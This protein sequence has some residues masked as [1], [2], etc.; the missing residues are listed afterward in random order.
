MSMRQCAPR[1]P[2]SRRAPAPRNIPRLRV[3]TTMLAMP[4]SAAA[5]TASALPGS[6]P[7]NSD[8][9]AHGSLPVLERNR[10]AEPALR[11]G[12]ECRIFPVFFGGANREMTAT[13]RCRDPSTRPM[14]EEPQKPA[15]QPR[16]IRLVWGDDHATHAA[17]RGSCSVG[18]FDLHRS[19]GA[20]RHVVRFRVLRQGRPDGRRGRQRQEGRLDHHRQRRDRDKFGFPAARLAPGRYSL[21]IRAVGYDLEGPKNADVAAAGTTTSTSSCGRPRT[22]P[23]SSPTRNGL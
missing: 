20:K 8:L 21:A 9:R 2:S 5:S 13:C 14:L 10:A 17:H 7:D 6:G 4:A 22:W 1:S 19:A 15:R 3:S 12:T 23:S 11:Q 18:R 16:P